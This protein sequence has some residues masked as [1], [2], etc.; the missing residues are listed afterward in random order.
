MAC[1]NDMPVILIN[2]LA[3]PSIS[4][5]ENLSNKNNKQKTR[6]LNKNEKYST[7]TQKYTSRGNEQ[8]RLTLSTKPI[9][10]VVVVVGAKFLI[11]ILLFFLHLLL[12]SPPQPPQ[13]PPA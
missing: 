7:V 11:C 1:V 6:S 5:P 12:I 3:R 10:R 4:P 8:S 9:N 13:R 2:K